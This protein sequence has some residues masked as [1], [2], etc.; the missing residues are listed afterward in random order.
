MLK[1]TRAQR[2]EYEAMQ[3]QESRSQALS[4]LRSMSYAATAALTD[5]PPAEFTP[6]RPVDF[7]RR[8]KRKSK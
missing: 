1:M 8:P 6:R 5:G 2:K 7:R 3:Q 4:R